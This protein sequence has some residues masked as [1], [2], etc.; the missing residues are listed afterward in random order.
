MYSINDLARAVF[1]Y[2][3]RTA[4]AKRNLKTY[5][6]PYLRPEFL[7]K[8]EGGINFDAVLKGL[9]APSDAA[10]EDIVDIFIDEKQGPELRAL[11]EAH[12]EKKYG[13]KASEWISSREVPEGADKELLNKMVKD[14]VPLAR[15]HIFEFLRHKM[16][17]W[18]RKNEKEIPTEKEKIPEIEI[19]PEHEVEQEAIDKHKW[20]EGLIEDVYKM[21]DRQ[22]PS[23]KERVILKLILNDMFLTVP[24]KTLV[25][26]AQKLK[27]SKSWIQVYATRLKNLMVLFLKDK[28]LNKTF[29]E[30]G[31]MARKEIEIPPYEET[32]K[33]PDNV[34]EFKKY[35][36]DKLGPKTTEGTK[37]ILLLLSEGKNIATVVSESKETLTNVRVVKHRYFDPWY[38]EWYEN[39]IEEVRKAGETIMN[40]TAETVRVPYKTP[41][42]RSKEKPWPWKKKEE[43]E[44]PYQKPEEK[45]KE[46]SDEVE[47]EAMKAHKAIVS[48]GMA[49]GDMVVTIT[50][51][52]E[53]DNGDVLT[54]KRDPKKDKPEFRYEKFEA[55][56]NE[57]RMYG[58]VNRSVNY[59][60]KQRINE[61]GSF[62]GSPDSMIE[63]D[64]VVQS[65]DNHE[66][67]VQ[68]DKYVE[69]KIK[70]EGM[71]P[72]GHFSTVYVNDK[73]KKK[74]MG[75]RKF[76]EA[77]RGLMTEDKVH[78]NRL[79]GWKK[80]QIRKKMGPAVERSEEEKT[81]KALFL[82]REDLK[83]EKVKKTEAQDAKKI[84]EL[85]RKISEL[86]VALKSHHEDT[87]EVED[88]IEEEMKHRK[89][90]EEIVQTAAIIPI[91]ADD[92]ETEIIA[93]INTHVA[94]EGLPPPQSNEVK[95][96]VELFKEYKQAWP[97][98]WLEPKDLNVLAR[99]LRRAALHILEIEHDKINKLKMT[100]E[101]RNTK[102]KEIEAKH[103]D[104]LDKAWKDFQ[105]VPADLKFR[106][107][108]FKLLREKD[109]EDLAKRKNTTWVDNDSVIEGV[110][111]NVQRALKEPLKDSP[112]DKGESVQILEKNK[113]RSLEAFLEEDLSGLHTLGEALEHASLDKPADSA[114]LAKINEHYS[115]SKKRFD[116]LTKTFGELTKKKEDQPQ[117]HEED[118]KQIEEIREELPSLGHKVRTMEKYLPDYKKIAAL[119]AAET[120]LA[121]TDYFA[122]LYSF[123]TRILWF[124]E[125]PIIKCADSAE[126]DVHNLNT[127]RASAVHA[128]NKLAS[129][130]IFA[131]SSIKAGIAE[132][133]GMLK[134]FIEAYSPEEHPEVTAY[135][136]FVD[137]PYL[138]AA[139][140]DFERARI[141]AIFPEAEMAAAERI[142]QDL[143]AMKGKKTKGLGGVAKA[144]LDKIL[145]NV[146]E[147]FKE[148]F[149]K[150]RI[151]ALAKRDKMPFDKANVR[152][153]KLEDA[154]AHQALS[155][156]ILKWKK[157]KEQ[158]GRMDK[159]KSPLGNRPGHHYDEIGRF[160]ES[161]L[162][163]IFELSPTDSNLP[164]EPSRGIPTPK[165][166]REK[167]EKE[168]TIQ[169][170][171]FTPDEKEKLDEEGKKDEERSLKEDFYGSEGGGGK[172]K[173]GRAKPAKV[174]PPSGTHENLKDSIIHIFNKD[175]QYIVLTTLAMYT[176]RI[177]DVIREL[178]E[179]EY[180]EVD[181]VIDA[182][183][184]SLKN[185]YFTIK[186]L[187]IE[188]SAGMLQ[189]P[190]GAPKFTGQPDVTINNLKEA[191]KA[192][193]K[194]VA[195]YDE[196]NHY[197][198]PDE[199]GV[200]PESL[201]HQ[202][203]VNQY[204]PR[205]LMEWMD[206]FQKHEKRARDM[207]L[208]MS[209]RVAGRFTLVGAEPLTEKEA[210]TQ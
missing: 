32:F 108:R 134:K 84:E 176:K 204:L 45:E 49:R 62:M 163:E 71:L 99:T 34:K 77:Y 168:F 28:D 157:I 64:G 78:K 7:D 141:K 115:A 53:Y 192:F 167:I 56:M 191:E 136:T 57:S 171:H 147:V 81:K 12:A 13:E 104:D 67:Q 20:E 59:T 63:I 128:I 76:H 25:E 65:G 94:T 166:I 181:A 105:K 144:E 52:A 201:K 16:M 18:I 35:V 195:I 79:Q 150:E 31:G 127:K 98:K 138:V 187:K 37:K 126:L 4:D 89:P 175:P 177:R 110:M 142:V 29:L 162:P 196:I 2:M 106:R 100:P 139:E 145:K 72:H 203:K 154:V 186:N 122:S 189:P 208:P 87:Q 178:P 198:A 39:K 151:E 117:D 137:G 210:F 11:L 193:D 129:K 82:L 10:L 165:E 15:K 58:K 102:I 200:P 190:P 169:H 114:E 103:R 153:K 143:G 206:F 30:E 27:L 9:D 54:G 48:R 22:V 185:L 125:S 107:D 19:P 73:T 50:F 121:A 161:H 113:Y 61:D 6:E 60:F 47:K 124:R 109:F 69:D 95:N 97:S 42:E 3:V 209:F 160:V 41:E 182:M 164:T 118:S 96:L 40:M 101:E 23:E 155:E 205:G 111:N 116:F 14:F 183:V 91:M 66:L 44:K 119:G 158:G 174:P 55:N 5:L 17:E 86:E 179:D 123:L 170:P 92:E 24:P 68:L 140:G 83:A 33:I 75:V 180:L 120:A 70:S 135:D 85:K 112:D 21:L 130:N 8:A 146:A 184:S 26:I 207:G 43:P 159:E 74:Y 149:S 173:K 51:S 132:T 202:P 188:P 80:L 156:F 133:R 194:I 88:I 1:A 199:I 131:K 152:L 93:E 197:I 172:K 38:E 46:K 36:D 90:S 148:G